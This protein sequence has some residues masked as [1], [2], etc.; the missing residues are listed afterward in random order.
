M[1]IVLL[2]GRDI[3]KLRK[4]PE[5][6]NELRRPLIQFVLVGSFECV[7]ILRTANAVVDRDVLYRLHIEMN[8][9]YL[10]KIL[11][12]PPDHIGSADIALFERLEI[13]RERPAVE[14]GV[15]SIRSDK[16]R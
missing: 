4:L 3:F 6:G 9:W 13:Y 14:S 10:F 2:I 16:G 12:Q 8:A 7:L 1:A 5:L 15:G 11:L